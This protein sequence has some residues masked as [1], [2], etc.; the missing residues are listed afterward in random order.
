MKRVVV[1]GISGKMGT[2]ISKQLIREK[3]IEL[4]GGFDK[5]NVGCDIGEVLGIGK[6]GYRVTN[7]YKEVKSLKPDLIVDFTSAKIVVKT[8]NWAIDNDI[9][10][11]VG[12]TGIMKEELEKIKEKAKSAKSKVFIAP[13]FSV[14]AVIMIKISRMISKYFDG[15][16]IIEFHHDQKKD[17]PSGTAVL[18]AEQISGQ[19][20]YT[21]SRL[22]DE[23]N[24][25]IE[26]SRGAFSNGIHIHSIRLRGLLAHQSVIFGSAGQTLTIR[27]DSLDR[28]SFY[29]GVI[30][31]IKNID[32]LSNYTYGLEKLLEI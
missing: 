19:K 2:T 22:K 5:D 21:G 6:T 29:P 1:F 32:S 17:A 28:T 27:H 18:T 3:D 11:I 13:N 14:G 24:E 20:K 4:V 31:A 9:N 15:C 12:T 7:S 10:I 23:E 16:E 8:I 26:C 25:N 30:L